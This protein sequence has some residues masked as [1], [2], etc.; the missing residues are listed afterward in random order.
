MWQDYLKRSGHG[1]YSV[2]TGYQRSE[3]S[4]RSS[5]SGSRSLVNLGLLVL[6]S[7]KSYRRR[8]CRR[9]LVATR[10]QK[11]KAK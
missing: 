11:E 9:D 7:R 10:A 4:S 3:G 6:R 2:R 8:L 5:D 1:R